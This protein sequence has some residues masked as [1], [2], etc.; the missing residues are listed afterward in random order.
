M[1]IL[2][3]INRFKSNLQLFYAIF[4]SSSKFLSPPPRCDVLIYDKCGSEV[5]MPYLKKYKTE[6]LAVRGEQIN[7]YCMLRASLTTDFWIGRILKAYTD[8]YI[9]CVTPNLCITFI[10]NNPAFYSISNRFSGVTTL[11][12]QNGLRD[13]WLENL[14]DKNVYKVD[15]M[16]VFNKFIGAIYENNID[17]KII[18]IG[19]LKNNYIKKNGNPIPGTVVFIST[20]IPE[21][22]GVKTIEVNGKLVLWAD[23]SKSECI[24]LNYLKQWCKDNEKQL[25][26]AGCSLDGAQAEK[27]FYEDKLDGIDWRYSARVDIY[28]TYKLID[29]AELVVTIDSTVGYES[30]ARGNKTAF[31]SCRG[32]FINRMDKTFGWPADLPDNGLFWTNNQDEIQFKRVMDYL[33]DVSDEKWEEIRKFYIAETMEFNPSNTRFVALLDQLLPNSEENFTSESGL[34]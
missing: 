1:V 4:I 6:I 12:I 25:I 19:S 3:F 32:Y 17:G 29:S 33:N 22:D 10:D 13:N 34:N 7:L 14:I 9:K 2:N 16:L 26:I 5:L 31:I 28:S 11:L 8:E 27:D 15:Y 18:E 30:M 21:P 20:Y 24:I 23:F